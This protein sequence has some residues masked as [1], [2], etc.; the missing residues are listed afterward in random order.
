MKKLEKFGKLIR[1]SVEEESSWLHIKEGN[2]SWL[3]ITKNTD[4]KQTPTLQ[5]IVNEYKV[6]PT[7]INRKSMFDLLSHFGCEKS[8]DVFKKNKSV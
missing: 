2:W 1:Y 3:Y 8:K 7:F 6:E 4:L 5:N